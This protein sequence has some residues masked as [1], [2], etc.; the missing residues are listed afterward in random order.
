MTTNESE[1]DG[2][3]EF[4]PADTRRIPSHLTSKPLPLDSASLMNPTV[5]N[6]R[7]SVQ[8]HKGPETL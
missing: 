8:I 4:E 3:E 1:A 6:L 5:P 2:A 7:T